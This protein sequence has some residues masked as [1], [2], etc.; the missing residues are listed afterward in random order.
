MQTF[1]LQDDISDIQ[2]LILISSLVEDVSLF[3]ATGSKIVKVSEDLR[4]SENV[5]TR[6]HGAVAIDVD[7]QTQEIFWSDVTRKHIRRGYTDGRFSHEAVISKDLGT[8]EGI[9]VDWVGRKL[10][11]TD[12]LASTIEVA[13]LRGQN[14]RKLVT[15]DLSKP[16]AIVVHSSG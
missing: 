12:S 1:K 6:L 8:V 11:W 9:A 7:I 15:K 16:R 3:V 4:S 14:R 5:Y 10:Y 13:G 2:L